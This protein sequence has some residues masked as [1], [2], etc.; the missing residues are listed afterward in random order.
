MFY[1][2]LFNF[3][4]SFLIAKDMPSAVTMLINNKGFMP[5][6]SNGDAREFTG[7]FARLMP[8]YNDGEP[9]RFKY[10]AFWNKTADDSTLKPI[11]QKI[12]E[13]MQDSL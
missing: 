11:V 1:R 10:C 3:S 8:L 5:I 4:G 12:I 2:R 7:K 6:I 9:I 13:L